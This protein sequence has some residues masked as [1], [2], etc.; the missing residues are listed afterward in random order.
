MK[1]IPEA[2]KML[3]TLKEINRENIAAEWLFDEVS[4]IQEKIE[5]MEQN[6]NKVKIE[7]VDDEEYDDED[8]E[9]DDEQV[10]DLVNA[11]SVLE[12]YKTSLKTRLDRHNESI[13]RIKRLQ[14][15]LPNLI[16]DSKIVNE[17]EKLKEMTPKLV[18]YSTLYDKCCRKDVELK[19][20][21]AE[22][23]KKRRGNAR[24]VRM[25]KRMRK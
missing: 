14:D 21:D 22:E 16:F 12:R 15:V 2:E 13:E 1:L 9:D 4:N 25:L 17:D 8:E 23:A 3:K 7:K 10:I 20:L 11:A 6:E 24:K 5:L 18:E 19:E